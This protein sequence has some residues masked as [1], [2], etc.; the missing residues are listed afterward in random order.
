MVQLICA[1]M[2]GGLL[3]QLTTFTVFMLVNRNERITVLYS[4][5]VFTVIIY[6][7]RLIINKYKL[8]RDRQKYNCYWLYTSDRHYP[9]VH[10]YMT[11][12]YAK[13]FETSRE[14][15]NYIELT[16]YGCEFDKPIDKA[17]LL[18]DTHLPIG[19][20]LEDISKFYKK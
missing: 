6:L 4:M 20:T 8:R 3:W 5:G 18:D 1:L 19:M 17:Y 14:A 11:K 16:Q 13:R 7:L 9:I 12:E 2:V 10:V 15:S